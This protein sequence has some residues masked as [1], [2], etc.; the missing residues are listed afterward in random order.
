MAAQ[1]EEIV[2]ITDVKGAAQDACAMRDALMKL[3]VHI[4]VKENTWT[5]HGVGSN[6]FSKPK[7]TLDLQNSGTA[8]RLLSFA[9]LRIGDTVYITGD[10]TL[11]SRI[12]LDFWKTL[13]IEVESGSDQRSLPLRIR[14]PFSNNELR[15]DVSKTSQYLSAIVLSMPARETPLKLAIEGDIVSKRH[16]QLSFQIAEECGSKNQFGDWHLKPWKCQPP[17]LVEIPYDASHI[18][19]WKLYEILHC[20]SLDFPVVE[21]VDSI[22]AEILLGLDFSDTQI[23]DLSEANDLITPLAAS[24]ALGGGGRIVGASHARYK[25]TNRIERTATMLAAFS[26]E[27]E[28]TED[29]L[30]IQGGQTPMQ[31]I[32]TIQT[33]GDHRM[34]MTA[35]ILATKVGAEIQGAEL[36]KVSFPTFLDFLQP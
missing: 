36:H 25:E 27:V 16:A 4:D 35:A 9:C 10:S 29:G 30:F 19:F 12:N 15:V 7:D 21:P 32:S 11:D 26:I 22:G 33:F 8:F 14:G 31:P 6:G 2:P 18:S 3:G 17:S 20:T 23:V 24:L 28:C 1:S 13:G 5:V 34:Q